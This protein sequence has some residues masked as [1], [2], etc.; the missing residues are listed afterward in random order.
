M[1]LHPGGVQGDGFQKED[2]NNN[3]N[4][5]N[6]NSTA[7]RYIVAAPVLPGGWVLL[8]DLSRFLPVTVDRFSGFRFFPPNNNTPYSPDSPASPD[9]GSWRIDAGAPLEDVVTV[10]LAPGSFTPGTNSSPQVLEMPCAL[11]ADGFARLR[12]SSLNCSCGMSVMKLLQMST[13]M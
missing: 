11:D 9:S 8:G 5:E 13:F 2:N 10:L 4:K 7:F 1:R 3:N 6:S 12:C